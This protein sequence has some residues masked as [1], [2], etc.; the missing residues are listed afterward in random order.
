MT[1]EEFLEDLE[2]RKN[3][4]VYVY[5]Y[6]D[7]YQ[8]KY[9]NMFAASAALRKKGISL[10]PNQIYGY[11]NW[12]QS[13]ESLDKI[14]LWFSWVKVHKDK[15]RV[16][17]GRTVKAEANKQKKRNE[18]LSEKNKRRREKA[19]I[20]KLKEKKAREFSGDTHLTHQGVASWRVNRQF[21]K[22]SGTEQR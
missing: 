9:T 6:T 8:W 5:R 4:T 3:D 13:A 20:K 21:K 17:D 10:K 2:K 7:G 16:L 12:G 11:C 18:Y 19:R 22:G 15:R 14:G 1:K